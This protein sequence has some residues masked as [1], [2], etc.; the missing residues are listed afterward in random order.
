MTQKT[1]ITQEDGRW[2]KSSSVP[3]T[4]QQQ[5]KGKVEG[6]VWAGVLSMLP[7]KAAGSRQKGRHG[8]RQEGQACSGEGDVPQE[9]RERGS[10]FI[11]NNL[12]LGVRGRERDERE[13][14]ERGE[15]R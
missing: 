9:G 7:G 1:G 11:S 4:A 8:G 5:N 10:I 12:Q 6:Q 3:P 2:W 14:S 13:R 15:R